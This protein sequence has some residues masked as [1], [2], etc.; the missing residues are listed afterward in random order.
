MYLVAPLSSPLQINSFDIS[1]K[2]DLDEL[3]GSV[4]K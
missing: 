1:E 4:V 3:V 2:A